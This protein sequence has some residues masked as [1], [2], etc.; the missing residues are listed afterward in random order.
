MSIDSIEPTIAAVYLRLNEIIKNEAQKPLDQ[1]GS[2]IVGCTLAAEGIERLFESYPT[3]VKIADIGA[4]MEY[5]G[6]E[7]LQE[8]YQSLKK[9]LVE[10]ETEVGN[11]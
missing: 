1:V 11:G 9:L 7:Y 10:L 6:E 3:L 8:Y 5:Q 2:Y 4:D